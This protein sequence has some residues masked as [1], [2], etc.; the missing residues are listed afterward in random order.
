MMNDK[1]K[2]CL[3]SLT[4]SF[5]LIFT[6]GL[7]VLHFFKFSVDT[8]ILETHVRALNNESSWAQGMFYFMLLGLF[9]M[10]CA[11]AL[12]W[13]NAKITL[14]AS[15]T[16]RILA[17]AVVMVAFLGGYRSKQFLLGFLFVALLLAFARMLNFYRPPIIFTQLDRART[18][19][20]QAVL[21]WLSASIVFIYI[22]I[23]AIVPLATP[24]LVQEPFEL[25]AIE[26]HYAMTV[27]PGSDLFKKGVVEHTNYGLGMPL[28]T[29]LALK[30]LALFGVSGTALVQAVKLNQLIA[31][32]MICIV[33][34]LINR[35]FFPYIM[36]LVL[37]MTAFTLS[38]ISSAVF[39]PNQS[40][41][42]Y[43]PIL[44]SLIV[45]V[46]EMRRAQLRIWLLASAS[47]VLLIISP[48]TGLAAT[49]GYIVA[50]VLKRYSPQTPVTSIFGSLVWF[51]TFFVATWLVCSVLIVGPLLK[52][53]SGGSFQYMGL[54][55]SGYAGRVDKPSVI[56]TLLFFVAT[57]VVLHAVWRARYGILLSVDACE[58]AI[59]T[60]MLVW[61][62]YYI[63]R[64]YECNLWFQLVLLVLLIAP[65]I[66]VER[67]QQL[68]SKPLRF[69]V[70]LSMLI[71]CLIGG[72]IASSSFQF[73][74]QGV[75]WLK[76]PHIGRGDS[77]ILDGKYLPWLHGSKFERQIN[78]LKG[79]SPSETLVLS[80]MSTYARLHGFN[81]GFPWYE[82]M[83]EVIH[84][85]NIDKII[86]WIEIQGPKYI[87]AD[88]PNYD[89]AKTAP[90][91]CQ[92]IQWYILRLVSYREISREAG[93]IV[94]ER[95][96]K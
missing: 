36:V 53:S 65:R 59:G 17:I 1:T 37:G 67:C 75:S 7:F 94:L 69:E 16:D 56:A 30:L 93:W 77:V 14:G 78:A 55:I 92:Q 58:A 76:E 25:S 26:G 51:G 91:H 21:F 33:C 20:F 13:P 18:Q 96:V 42:R 60:I 63:K 2:N 44:A 19:T 46:L 71:A 39:Y 29:A 12:L 79:Y 50:V 40:G 64:M 38:N 31:I 81:D 89:I 10:L 66:T 70:T 35:K 73:A 87:L 72:Q 22:T 43:I 34:V 32:A 6:I 61:L 86:D 41:I 88:D 23:F 80:V 4:A 95:V 49:A 85:K 74:S 15:R 57:T 45:L 11:S 27:L 83:G 68:F 54:F 62:M 82:P 47:A 8:T 24:L 52:N 5:T 90:E 28:L 84:K 48:E 3:Y 9:A